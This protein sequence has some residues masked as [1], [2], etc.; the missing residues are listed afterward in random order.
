MLKQ[1]QKQWRRTM[2]ILILHE[3]AQSIL[4]SETGCKFDAAGPGQRR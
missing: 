3:E 1:E 4:P 2:A